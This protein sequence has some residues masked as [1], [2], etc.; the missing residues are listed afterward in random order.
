M[1]IDVFVDK[2][3][4]IHKVQSSQARVLDPMVIPNLVLHSSM[5]SQSVL[6]G[7]VS[8]VTEVV[9]FKSSIEMLCIF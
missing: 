3:Q 1:S 5:I 9:S 6:N 7:T 2:L 4:E 8:P